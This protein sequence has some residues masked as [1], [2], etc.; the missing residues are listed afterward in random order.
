[1][2]LVAADVDRMDARRAPRQQDMREAAGRGAEIEGDFPGRIVAE[3]IEPGGE[4]AAAARYPRVRRLG[5]DGGSVRERV[6]WL[7]DDLPVRRHA[8][9]GNGLLR[10]GAAVEI[11]AG[12]EGDIGTP[13]LPVHGRAPYRSRAGRTSVRAKSSPL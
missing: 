6:R 10:L 11:A 9:G 3:G 7:P 2:E 5:H 13:G 12:D 1:M 4:L 8:A